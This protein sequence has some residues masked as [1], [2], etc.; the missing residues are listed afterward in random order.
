[1]KK[2]VKIIL[3]SILSISVVVGATVTTLFLVVFNK[4]N[5]PE[6]N[7]QNIG[8]ENQDKYNIKISGEKNNYYVNQKYELIAEVEPSENNFEYI[9]SCNDSNLKFENKK[10]KNVLFTTTKRGVYNL[11]IQVLKDSKEITSKEINLNFIEKPKFTIEFNQP[12]NDYHINNSYTI[13]T[14]LTPSNLIEFAYYEFTCN[15]QDINITKN[16]DSIVIKPTS[17]GNYTINVN[18]FGDSQKSEN[19]ASNS[20]TIKVKDYVLNVNPMASYETYTSNKLTVNVVPNNQNYIY[21]WTTNDKNLVLTNDNT[22]T[23]SFNSNIPGN[24]EL[25]VEVYD[26]NNNFLASKNNIVLNFVNASYNIDF[27]QESEFGYGIYNKIASDQS[28]NVDWVKNRVIDNKNDFFKIPPTI[29]INFD[30]N[31]NVIIENLQASDNDR[32]I[33]FTLKLNNANNSG[34]TINKVIK[35][36]GFKDPNNNPSGTYT[37]EFQ[38]NLSTIEFE[39]GDS[40]SLASNSYIYVKTKIIENKERF[41]K[42]PPNVPDNFNWNNNVRIETF[43]CFDGEGKCTFY[44]T[45]SNSSTDNPINNTI[46]S[47]RI[48]FI[49]FK[50]GVSYDIKFDSTTNQ[51]PFGDPNILSSDSSITDEWIIQRVLDN[52]N[53]IFSYGKLPDDYNWK[54]NLTVNWK[55]YDE[56]ARS[57]TFNLTLNNS[58]NNKGYIDKTITFNDFKQKPWSTSSMPND[59]DLMINDINKPQGITGT[60]KIQDA[61]NVLNKYG[62]V[63]SFALVNKILSDILFNDLGFTNVSI[64]MTNNNFNEITFVIT[65]IS[66]NSIQN[67]GKNKIPVSGII[68]AWNGANISPNDNVELTIKY[69]RKSDSINKGKD[70]FDGSKISWTPNAWGVD[71]LNWNGIGVNFRMFTREFTTW[72]SVKVNNSIIKQSSNNDNRTFFLFINHYNGINYLIQSSSIINTFYKRK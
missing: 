1:M 18:V 63:R 38:D 60:V 30:W 57:I 20:L 6:N 9:W 62:V 31:S 52:K 58:N 43:T 42:I 44:I 25:N 21:Q 34:T 33:T 12:T 67:W 70:I 69:T 41:F 2:I 49:G 13:S 61:I 64:K 68:E 15:R 48:T 27:K 7:Q 16:G 22:K 10:S 66:Q 53:K 40:N 11:K 3:I 51:Y 26:Q 32:W 45:L 39:Y 54:N 4:N 19:I 24:Y 71:T 23:V 5:N 29:P 59:T 65:G 14:T 8:D 72:G 55:L 50:K 56:S 47:D 35:F 36:T 46:W 17:T 28:V 37:I